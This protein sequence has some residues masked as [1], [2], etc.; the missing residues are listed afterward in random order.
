LTQ[1]VFELLKACCAGKGEDD[2]VFTR[3]N[4]KPVKG[5]REAWRTPRV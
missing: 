3:K 4:S 5:F 2:Y 1:R